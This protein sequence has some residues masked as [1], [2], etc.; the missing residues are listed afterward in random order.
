MTAVNGISFDIAEGEAVGLMGPNG[1]GKTT[2]LNLIFGEIK[3]DSGEMLF[4]GQKITGMAPH[5]ICRR[6]IGRTYQI[7]LPYS[8]L[9]VMQN[10][11]VSAMYAG[12]MKK[13]VAEKTAVELLELTGLIHLRD[14]LTNTLLGVTL[15]RLEIARALASLPSLL[16]L[17]EVAGGL[18][19][20]EIPDLLE[21]LRKIRGRGAS[22]LIIEHVMSVISEAVDR[23][24]VID[25]GNK[26]AEDK[27]KDIMQNPAVI[28]AY[29]GSSGVETWMS[30]F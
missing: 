23:I 13:N 24:L 22:I 29:L 12:N 3:L 20:E 5:Q 1:A 2:L 27:P 8:N 7:P 16:L 26:I 9:T 30:Q 11:M 21:L 14:V 4:K 15:K 18:T 28:E 19:E 25:K 17:D 10:L 6:G